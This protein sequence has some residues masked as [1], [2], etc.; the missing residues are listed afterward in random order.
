MTEPI[1]EHCDETVTVCPECD[2]ARIRRRTPE[3]PSSPDHQTNQWACLDCPARFDEPNERPKQTPGGR[4]GL[5][6]Q[7]VDADPDAIGG[8]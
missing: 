6:G 7:L 8:D 3:H 1:H 2:S 4:A 5:A